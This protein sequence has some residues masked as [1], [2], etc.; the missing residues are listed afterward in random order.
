[1]ARRRQAKTMRALLSSLA[2]TRRCSITSSP[3]PVCRVSACRRGRRTAHLL[4]V[5]P[6]AFAFA[7]EPPD[8]N[9]LLDFL[10]LPIGLLPRSAANKLAKVVAEFPGVGGEKWLAA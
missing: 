1:M 7:W 3:R 10:L 4:Q 6:L 8:P 2:R 5:L 9:R